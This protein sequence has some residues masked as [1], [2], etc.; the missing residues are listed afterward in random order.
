MNNV[1]VVMKNE[2]ETRNIVGVYSTLDAAKIE[3]GDDLNKEIEVWEVD[4]GCVEIID[5][6]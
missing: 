1:Y 6:F 4:G 3:M 2:W 5:N